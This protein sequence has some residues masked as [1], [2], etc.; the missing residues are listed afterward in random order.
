MSQLWVVLHTHWNIEKVQA[1]LNVVLTA[2]GVLSVWTFGRFCRQH[3]TTKIIR[4]H[5]D[6]Q[7]PALLTVSGPGTIYEVLLLLRH[8]IFTA[9]NTWLLARCVFVTVFSVLTFLS[10]VLAN[11]SLHK[12]SQVRNTSVPGLMANAHGTGYSTNAI[13]TSVVWNLTHQALDYAKFPSDQLLDFLPDLS[14]PWVY[15]A[16]QWNSSWSLVCNKTTR[17]PIDVGQPSGATL[18]LTNLFGGFPDAQKFF[19]SQYRNS[20]S[21]RLSTSLCGTID[22][23]E[24][25][26]EEAIYYILYSSN[27]AIDDSMY[28]NDSPLSFTLGALGVQHIPFDNYTG[29]TKN[30]RLKA[31]PQASYLSRIECTLDRSR[32]VPD[33]NYTAWP[34][35]NDTQS[36]V[37][38]YA[39]YNRWNTIS[40]FLAGDANYLTSADELI[41]FFQVYMI[42]KDT[43]E[44][45]SPIHRTMGVVFSTV[46][47]SVIS[48]VLICCAW[49]VL[50]LVNIRYLKFWVQQRHELGRIPDSTLDWM[51]HA[52]DIE[53][54]DCQIYFDSVKAKKF[55]DAWYEPLADSRTQSRV[56]MCK[57]ICSK[58]TSSN[59]R[60][61]KD[62]LDTK[63]AKD[64]STNIK[65]LPSEQVVEIVNES[66]SQL[67]ASP[68]ENLPSEDLPSEQITEIV[69]VGS[70]R[71]E[72]SLPKH[73]IEKQGD[74]NSTPAI[75]NASNALH[76]DP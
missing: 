21:F 53:E 57:G 49:M 63:Q 47:L 35:T 16:D 13:T 61:S 68:I 51:I 3:T 54:K 9:R 1:G 8:K 32:P 5:Q 71:L 11:I 34:W 52:C 18:P 59:L 62:S 27:P 41:R 75:E 44:F 42:I 22:V 31:A 74:K 60:S 14:V 76:P 66:S 40:A 72:A 10:G 48:L 19:P 67:E 30:A 73:G 37:Q 23:R 2:L 70:S 7:L 39:D 64:H 50:L 58:S 36:L 29:S 28:T 4:H 38:A 69:S 65:S 25:I 24:S 26:L 56:S 46:E 20:S 43:W 17:V 12:G 55:S 45:S 33:A 15:R 6:V